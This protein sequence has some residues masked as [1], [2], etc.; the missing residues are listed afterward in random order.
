MILGWLILL[1]LAGACRHKDKEVINPDPG[2]TPT[3]CFTQSTPRNGRVIAGEYILIYRCEGAKSGVSAG[4][5]ASRSAELLRRH[6]IAQPFVVT[7]W[8]GV[9]NGFL[10]RLTSKQADALRNDAEIALVEPDRIVSI[11]SCITVVD[12][13]TMAW[14]TRRTGYGDGTGKTVWIIDSGI[15]ASHPDLTVDLA[16]SRCFI[17]DQTSFEDQNGHGTHVAGIVGA[18]NNEEGIVGVASGA[19]LVA[20]KVLGQLGEGRISAVLRALGYVS[21][22][23]HR[24]EV[25]N[26]SLVSDTISQALDQAVTDIANRG[27]LFAIAAGNKAQKA[28]LISPSRVNHPNVFTVS[29][30]DDTDTW[31]SFSNF[32]NDAVDVAA[33]GVMILSTTLG[34]HYAFM[35]GTSLATPHVAGLLLLDGRIK[36][37]SGTVKGDPDGIPDPIAHK[38]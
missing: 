28:S 19:N 27:I 9:Q 30:M 2:I 7:A 6:G 25:V 23:A 37:T 32:G 16:Y 11:A 1:V 24:G 12:T 15:D 14:G 22:H 17:Q 31:A 33:P 36:A 34:G 38:W 35:S 8:E 3:P 29:A 5:L 21:Q 18:K 13:S 26:M 20:L 10:C 4:R